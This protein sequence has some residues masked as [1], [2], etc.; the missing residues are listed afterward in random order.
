MNYTNKKSVPQRNYQDTVFRKLFSEPEA[1]IELFNALEGTDFKSDTLVEFT[2]LEDAVY[3]GLKNDLG[4]I[5][6]D[7]FLL[8]SESQSTINH[9]MPL[10]ML[11]Y[12]ARTYETII[13]MAELYWRKNLKIPAPEFFVFYTG[14]EK[15]DVSELRLSDS[16]L[17]DAPE[18]SLELIVKVIKMEYNK[19]NDNDND[20]TNKVLERSEKLRGYSTLLGYIRTYRREGYGLK[21]AIDTAISRCICENILKDFLEHNSPEVGSMLYNDITNEEFA[22]IRAQ[23]AREDA[24]KEG[25][26]NLISTYKEFNL[27]RD[28][29]L[30]KLLEK[31]PMDKDA[32]LAYMENYDER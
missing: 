1:A 6:N 11:E 12:I 24:R 9:N 30:K 26:L 27:S 4:F 29:A 23:E 31:Y 3:V 7:K 22:E 10:R 19:D 2:T 21:E 18:N 5:I 13:P 28:E 16:Y 15:W 14:S 25:I 8:L 17:G 32:A 20:K